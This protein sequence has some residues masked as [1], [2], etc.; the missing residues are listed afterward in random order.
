MSKNASIDELPR[1]YPDEVLPRSPVFCIYRRRSGASPSTS[2]RSGLASFQGFHLTKL[3]PPFLIAMDLKSP[4]QNVIN[5][6]AHPSNKNS[7]SSMSTHPTATPD[8]RWPSKCRWSMQ[9]PSPAST[10]TVSVEETK[11]GSELSSTLPVSDGEINSVVEPILEA[12]G[13]NVIISEITSQPENEDDWKTTGLLPI[14]TTST[15]IPVDSP[16][17]TFVPSI[18]AGAKPLAFIPPATH[19]IHATP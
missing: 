4:L 12:S 13:G 9:S 1:K 19:P 11:A 3:R 8:P 17:A 6:A 10:Y 18:G 14:S 7:S 15:E 5:D 16:V 2:T